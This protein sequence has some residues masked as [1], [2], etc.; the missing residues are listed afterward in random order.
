MLRT[1]GYWQKE[2]RLE[3]KEWGWWWWGFSSKPLNWGWGGLHGGKSLRAL[4]GIVLRHQVG[5]VK[6]CVVEVGVGDEGREDQVVGSICRGKGGEGEGGEKRGG[7]LAQGL[8][9]DHSLHSLSTASTLMA[10]GIH[11]AHL[12][13]GGRSPGWGGK[14]RTDMNKFT[15]S[16]R[17]LKWSLG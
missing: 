6:G 2:K 17:A 12:G 11:Q 10:E 7:E 9:C 14:R 4:P 15:F 1:K 3:R 16:T 5:V 13:G 8:T